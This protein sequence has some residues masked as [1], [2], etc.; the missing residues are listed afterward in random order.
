[1]IKPMVERLAGDG[2]SEIVHLGEVGQPLDARFVYLP[3]NHLL[4]GTVNGA[5]SVTG[6]ITASGGVL[7]LT[8]T[9]TFASLAVAA[10]AGS[11]LKI[12]GT[13]SSGAIALNNANQTLELGTTAAL[14]LTAAETM[15]LGTIKLDGG[16]LT[17]LSGLTVTSGSVTGS[18]T[19]ATGTNISGAAAGTIKASSGTLDIKGTVKPA[20]A[21]VEIES[22]CALLSPAI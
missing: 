9:P 10:V 18:G 4:I 12:E 8:G 2:D 14:T 7:D 1:M 22:S 17:D 20:I 11:D 6:A 16:T 3:K 5:P 21:D 15:T 19:I 13:L